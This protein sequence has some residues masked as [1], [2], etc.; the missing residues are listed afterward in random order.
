[1]APRI[2]R[3]VQCVFVLGVARS[4]YFSVSVAPNRFEGLFLR[5]GCLTGSREVGGVGFPRNS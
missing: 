3:L 5:S 2:G 1:M 4:G